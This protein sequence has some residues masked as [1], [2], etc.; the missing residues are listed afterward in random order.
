MDMSRFKN[1][2][3]VIAATVLTLIFTTYTIPG[4]LAETLNVSGIA[5]SSKITFPG[6][7]GAATAET[8]PLSD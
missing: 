8:H 3:A 7:S 6:Y 4:A 2:F 5:K 1:H